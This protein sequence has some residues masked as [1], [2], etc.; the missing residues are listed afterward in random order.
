VTEILKA[1]EEGRGESGDLD[2]LEA[3]TRHLWLGR[4]FCALAPGAMEPLKSALQYFREDFERH[5]SEKQ[6]PWR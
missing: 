3:H 2:I 1:I 4:T 5:I 6:C